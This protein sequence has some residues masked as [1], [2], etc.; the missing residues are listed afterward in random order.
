MEQNQLHM[1]TQQPFNQSRELAKTTSIVYLNSVNDAHSYTSITHGEVPNFGLARMY[2]EA[3]YCNLLGEPSSL[4][5]ELIHGLNCQDRTHGTSLFQY[6][7]SGGLLR[8]G[9]LLFHSGL[10]L[11]LLSIIG[12]S[13]EQ[14]A[15]IVEVI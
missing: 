13:M 9:I 8:G 15:T 12:L 5:T 4:K 7:R 10:D 6:K 14:H 1:K 11:Q 3:V 2:Q